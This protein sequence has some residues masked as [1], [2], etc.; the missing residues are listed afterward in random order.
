MIQVRSRI[1]LVAAVLVASPLGAQPHLADTPWFPVQEGTTWTYRL[2][3]H[4][5]VVRIA[6]P[7]KQG[8][9]WCARVET[10]DKNEVVA[11]QHVAVTAEG[12]SRVAHN[13]EKIEPPLLLLKLPPAKGQ[14]WSV[15][16]KLTNRSGFDSY[17][18]KFTS[19]PIDLSVPAIPSMTFQLVRV[20]TELKINGRALNVTSW[21][22]EKVGL[23]K[24]RIVDGD[25]LQDM[26]L[27]KVEF[28][29]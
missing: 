13:G 16:S 23:V 26:V 25:R 15:D 9:I 27:E 19:E 22:M 20:S 1:V 18:A 6:K 17:Q 3:G 24:Q 14:S 5:V 7:E 8:K 11:V 29:K 12:I 28:P 21:Y 2:E 4:R 10:L